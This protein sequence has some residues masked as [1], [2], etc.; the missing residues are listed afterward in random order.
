MDGDQLSLVADGAAADPR[1]LRRE[2]SAAIDQQLWTQAAQHEQGE[3]LQ[4]GVDLCATRLH[5]ARLRKRGQHKEANFLMACLTGA[6]WPLQR[7]HDCPRSGE[8]PIDPTC[9]RCEEG[10]AET[11]LHRHWLCAGNLFDHPNEAAKRAHQGLSRRAQEEAMDTPCLWFRGL[12]PAEYTTGLLP[13]PA[14]EETA[15]VFGAGGASTPGYLIRKHPLYWKTDGSGG[16]YGQDARL[17]GNELADA[18]AEKGALLHEVPVDVVR[19]VS[20]ADFLAVRI[21][22]QLYTTA[23]QAVPE[24]KGSAKAPGSREARR[25]TLHQLMAATNH[26]LLR[27]PLKLQGQWHCF[28]CGHTI[29]HKQLREWLLN[30]PCVPLLPTTLPDLFHACQPVLIGLQA[31]HGSHK[32]AYKRGIWWCVA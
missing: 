21:Q 7:Q 29:A 16:K 30:V 24:L 23:I 8:T 19:A 4:R 28:R 3:G 14:S 12:L 31:T 22:K 5:L 26:D 18:F 20:E 6:L 1:H 2:I 32:L 10:C 9:K 11:F 15:M 25:L 27:D 13:P 17:V